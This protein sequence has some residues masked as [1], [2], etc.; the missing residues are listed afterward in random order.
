ML[1]KLKLT[2]RALL[3]FGLICSLLVIL[4]GAA[5]YQM[6]GI[7]EAVSELR[8]NW[9]PSV[10]QAGKIEMA[11]LLYRLD[12]RRFV[13]DDDRM[14][15]E[16]IQKLNQAREKLQVEADAY[17]PLVSSQEERAIY[18]Q[19]KV[20]ITQYERVTDRLVEMSRTASESELSHYIRDVTKP[21]A[22]IMQDAIEALIKIN[23]KGADTSSEGAD[24]DY[25]TGRFVVTTLIVLAVLL[26]IVV[27]IMFTRSVVN[28]VVTLLRATRDIAEGNLGTAIAT[29]GSDELTELQSATDKMRTSLRQT[30][31]HIANAS[32]QLASAAEEMG[33]ITQQSTLGAQRQNQET[34]MAA[35]AVNQMTAAVE[36]VARNASSASQSTQMSERSAV[37]GQGR[38]SHTVTSIEKLNS[39]I[40][41]TCAEVEGLAAKT[42]SIARVLDVIGSIAEQTNLL[43]LNA[44]IEAARAGEQGRGFAVVADEVRALAHRTQTS[45]Q[46]IERMIQDIQKDSGSAVQSMRRSSEEAQATLSS[47]HEAGT[48]IRDI[49]AA[50]VDINERN[51]MIA[52]AS[53]QQAQVARAVD[54]NLVSIR[55]LSLQGA[56]SAAQT[57]G[58]SQELSRL[59]VD[60]NRLV[61]R[62]SI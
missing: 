51:L 3:A 22:L 28:P 24:R 37:T 29:S 33:A 32:G 25:Q 16:S 43:A 18:D 14:G 58:A 15:S 5:L 45:T 23:E 56:S 42:Q 13:M 34:E 26:T 47:A 59:A 52:A 8:N 21:S 7:V 61:T 49:T 17:A 9:L 30:I 41:Q 10:R 36:E 53:E 54:E 35:T 39:S 20:A 57:A 11:G 27:A 6:H 62:F 55:D 4:G 46:E 31:E 40:Q 2:T 48:A 38:V 60:L 1:R 19:I 12:A 50:I 44:A